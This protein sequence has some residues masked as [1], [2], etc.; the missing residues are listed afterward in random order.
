MKTVGCVALGLVLAAS[1]GYPQDTPGDKPGTQADSKKCDLA[2]VETRIYCERCDAFPSEADIEKGACKKC[3][4]KVQQV[5]ACVKTAF[6][7]HKHGE[8]EVL[9]SRR[10]C[11]PEVKDCCAEVT[12]LSRVMYKCDACGQSS[13]TE[14]GVRHLKDPCDGKVART[15]EK[16]GTFPHGGEETVKADEAPKPRQGDTPK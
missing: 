4:E 3:K 9:H 7:C 15:C 13:L 16:S 14:K 2:K 8:S 10:C 6:R 11:R 1:L 5:S 12:L